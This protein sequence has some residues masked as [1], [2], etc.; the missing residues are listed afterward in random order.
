M[1]KQLLAC[2]LLFATTLVQGQMDGIYV[3]DAGNFN[4]PPWQILRYDASGA[5]P[6]AFITTNLNWPQDIV[7]LEDS[8]RVLISNLG[9][10]KI[11]KYDATTGAYISD[12]ATGIAGPTRMKIGVDGLLYVLQWNGTGTVRRYM[13]DGTYVGEFTTVGVPQSIGIDWDGAGNLY[14]SSYTADL[15]RKFDPSGND[16]GAFISTNLVG[17]TNIWFDTN[18]DLIVSD[19]DG[20]AIKRFDAT[21]AFQ[22]T[23]I[24]GVSFTEG[25][26]HYPNGNFLIGNGATSSV[27]LFDPDGTYLQDLIPSGSGGLITPNAIVI[28]DAQVGLPERAKVPEVAILFPSVGSHFHLDP[29]LAGVRSITVRSVQGELVERL[30]QRIWNADHLAAGIYIVLA[31]RNDGSMIR[32]R[33]EVVHE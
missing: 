24:S 8:N 29:S 16:L 22:G 13:L 5:D 10:N 18:G 32:Q 19:Y 1:M 17:P 3:S 6:V 28:R 33:I 4:S 31:E 20:A 9:T 15:V 11:T 2:S 25:I 23:F 12:F 21:G 27:K 7:F 26:A 30:V 14:V